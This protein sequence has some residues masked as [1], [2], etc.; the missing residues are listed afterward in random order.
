MGI[1]STVVSIKSIPWS[2]DTLKDATIGTF[3]RMIDAACGLG[4]RLIVPNRR[5]YP[6]STSYTPEE[7]AALQRDSPHDVFAHTLEKQGLYLL[8]FIDSIIQVH[9]LAKVALAGWS[10]GAMFLTLVAGAIAQVS[11]EV[12][13]RVK[14]H[15]RA[16]ILWG[17]CVCISACIGDLSSIDATCRPRECDAWLC[18]AINRGLANAAL[19]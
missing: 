19:R 3:R 15:V 17:E 1:R 12:R 5:L 8:E 7:I 6:G 18:D 9:G 14:A 16:L 11:E 4:Y 2:V 10:L 13:N